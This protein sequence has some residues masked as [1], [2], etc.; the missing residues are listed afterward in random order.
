MCRV[1]RVLPI[2]GLAC[3]TAA[4]AGCSLSKHLERVSAKVESDYAAVRNWNELPHRTISWQ[5]ALA[6]M[7]RNNVDIIKADNAVA[8]A[9]R[10]SLSVYTDMIP[11]VSY[12]GYFSETINELTSNFSTDD[13]ESRVNVTFNIPALTQIPYRVYSNKAK[14]FAAIK[15]REGKEREI[16]SKLYQTM[17]L[18]ELNL[19]ERALATEPTD[20]AKDAKAKME[21]ENQARQDDDKYWKDIATVVGDASARWTVLPESMPRIH[22]SDYRNRLDKLDPLIVCNFAM[23]LEQAR[24]KQYSVAL[25]YLPTINTNLYS[26]SLFS[27][28]G[29]T[30]S[31]TFLSGDD[32]TISLSISYTAD[33]KLSVWNTYQNNKQEYDLTC[34]S[35]ADELREHKAQVETLKRSFDEYNSWRNFMLKSIANLEKSRPE[36]AEEYISRS[37]ELLRMKREL[38]Q[39]EAKA[40]ESEAAIVLE[41]GM[42]GDPPG[43]KP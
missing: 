43:A 34:R 41:Y 19:Q 20:E 29:G 3:L 23:R 2:I 38:I 37:S 16:V 7:R 1:K 11:G 35:V 25:R 18:R 10:E 5:Q 36:S 28:T 22:W 8:T 32:T 21:K 39:Q 24:L 15:A 14:T 27:S 6:M 17:R 31:G 30:Y 33:T 9:E 4:L 12:Y 42:P 13:M 26:P 40:V